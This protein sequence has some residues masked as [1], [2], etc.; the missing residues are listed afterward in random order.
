MSP[1]IGERLVAECSDRAS[2]TARG[3]V[4]TTMYH[5]RGAST[6]DRCHDLRNS[7]FEFASEQNFEMR[8]LVSDIAHGRCV[9]A[10]DCAKPQQIGAELKTVTLVKPRTSP[11]RFD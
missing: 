7:F 6:P 3:R 2:S 9:T 8:R 4:V 11:L 10:G 5:G 1:L